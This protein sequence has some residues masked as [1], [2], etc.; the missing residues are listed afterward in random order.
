MI[1]PAE[2]NMNIIQI[3][4][5]TYT[6]LLA[7]NHTQPQ[8]G[9]VVMTTHGAPLNMALLESHLITPNFLKEELLG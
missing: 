8:C 2:I 7:M 6:V 4:S 1:I 3:M 5:F 9:L